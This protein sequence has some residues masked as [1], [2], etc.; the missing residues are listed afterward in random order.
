L[1]AKYTLEKPKEQSRMDNYRETGNTGHTRHKNKI[2]QRKLNI[3]S[4]T[5]PGAGER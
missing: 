4:N 2:Q 3:M 1:N 5:D